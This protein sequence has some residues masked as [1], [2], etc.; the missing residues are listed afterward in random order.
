M[1]QRLLCRTTYFVMVQRR[2]F[3]YIDSPEP[4]SI[5]HL[6]YNPASDLLY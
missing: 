1:A 4:P 5:P 3:L 6:V 2:L